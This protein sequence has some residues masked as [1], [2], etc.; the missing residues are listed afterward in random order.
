MQQISQTSTQSWHHSGEYII[1]YQTWTPNSTITH[2]IQAA[3]CDLM[4]WYGKLC[5][6]YCV[7]YKYWL[8]VL[9]AGTACLAFTSL[10]A[11]LLI[12]SACTGPDSLVFPS[13][14]SLIAYRVL[15]P[16][17]GALQIRGSIQSKEK[18][19]ERERRTNV[20]NSASSNSKGSSVLR[21]KEWVFA[22]VHRNINC[23]LFPFTELHWNASYLFKYWPG[24][25]FMTFFSSSTKSLDPIKH[26]REY[27]PSL[28]NKVLFCATS[29]NSNKHIP[30]WW[31][32][33]NP[34]PYISI[35]YI[36]HSMYGLNDIM[37]KNSCN[38][39]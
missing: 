13:A 26:F 12:R 3:Q 31:R 2:I 14:A 25:H 23:D 21:K 36:Y 15:W 32:S 11:L 9:D 8:C 7:L 34:H 16:Q 10:E 30:L 28:L 39:V 18:H 22:H 33:T 20:S 24:V 4:T 17:P 27:V 37:Y 38:W 19:E 1:L 5:D 6:V 35:K 29:L